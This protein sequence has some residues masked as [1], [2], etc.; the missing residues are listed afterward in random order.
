MTIGSN[1]PNPVDPAA[2]R[3]EFDESLFTGCY[4]IDDDDELEV[5]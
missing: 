3:S 1:A 4:Q 5:N 2:T